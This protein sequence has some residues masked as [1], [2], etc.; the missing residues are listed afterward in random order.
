MMP[1]VPAG[2]QEKTA[3]ASPRFRA[4][5]PGLV[6]DGVMVPVLVDVAISMTT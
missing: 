5:Y 3:V 6:P 2:E 1:A 4:P